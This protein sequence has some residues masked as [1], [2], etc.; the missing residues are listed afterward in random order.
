MSNRAQE[1]SPLCSRRKF[2]VALGGGALAV[3]TGG[4]LVLTG[5]FLTPNVLF[6]PPSKFLVGKPD[7]Y[8]LDSVI[9]LSKSKVFI[10]REE[11]G[12][13]YA[14]SAVC[15]H[16]GCIVNWKLQDDF[17]ACPCHGSRFN[18]IGEV[19]D[20]PAPKPLQHFAM[21]LTDEGFLVVDKEIIV[22]FSE[23][24]KV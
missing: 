11:A 8:A 23:I 13:F 1:E 3:A 21:S 9:Y 18:R 4:G 5:D 16:L 14:L 17:I 12:Y 20:G 2:F 10:I 7:Q 15:T 22:D 24:L 19:I 6:E